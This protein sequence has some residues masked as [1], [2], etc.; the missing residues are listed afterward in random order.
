M[1]TDSKVALVTGGNRGIGYELVRQLAL[2]GFK[3]ILTSRDSKKGLEA[4]NKL[5]KSNLEVSFLEMDV[6]NH[7]S[8]RQAAITVDQHFG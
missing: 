3:V 2:K 1:F 8:I 7:E 6:N 5:R 4:V